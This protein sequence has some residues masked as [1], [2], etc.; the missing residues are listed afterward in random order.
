MSKTKIFISNRLPDTFDLAGYE[1]LDMK[2]I[3]STCAEAVGDIIFV[4]DDSQLT[5]GNDND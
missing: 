4:P 5:K 3:N 2:E 1:A